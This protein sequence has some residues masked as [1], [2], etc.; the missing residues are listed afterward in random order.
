MSGRN[1]STL[2]VVI[3]SCSGVVLLLLSVA[4]VANLEKTEEIVRS[5][6]T[7]A[8]RENPLLAAERMLARMGTSVESTSRIDEL[9]PA[10]HVVVLA[11]EN[12]VL[13][14]TRA[15][16][17][18]SWVRRGGYLIVGP[19]LQALELDVE[20]YEHDP[21]R[22][23]REVVPL[24]AIE[25]EGTLDVEF[26]AAFG[27]ALE[28]DESC[29]AMI[30]TDHGE[31]TVVVLNDLRFV[32]SV[33]IGKFAHAR[34]LW[35]LLQLAGE[36]RA[37]LLVYGLGSES[38]W[39]LLVRHAWPA[40]L[41]GSL[42]L[43]VW[44][45]GRV[46]RF[47]PLIPAPPRGSRALMEHVEALGHF[48]WRANRADTLVDG[49][50]SALRRQIVASRPDLAVMDREGRLDALARAARLDSETVQAALEGAPRRREEFTRTI[51]TLEKL[52]REL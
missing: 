8:A 31:G 44:V 6:A 49:A 21:G 45:Q 14:R 43:A 48:L 2:P 10:G 16:R 23:R 27:L 34:Y 5:D 3:V 12:R 52:R 39:T 28:G 13:T 35:Q 26:F 42:L 17:L 32:R 30:R 7:G 20:E 29:Y 37:V 50:R 46:V 4:A 19:L 47:G 36:G 11:A 1:G 51:R 41:V 9:P 25:G 18:L 33:E 24:D 38:I 15:E 40:L 22:P